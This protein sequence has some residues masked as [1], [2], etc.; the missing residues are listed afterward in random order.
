MCELLLDYL[1]VGHIHQSP[2]R[3]PHYDDEVSFAIG[4]LGDH[5]AITIPF[6]DEHLPESHKRTQYLA[7]RAELLDHWE[8]RAKRRRPCMVDGCEKPRRAHGYCREHL[9]TFLEQ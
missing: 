1:A 7:G 4:A 2:R 9:W 3:K 5:L 8:H 6:M